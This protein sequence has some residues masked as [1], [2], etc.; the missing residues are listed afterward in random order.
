MKPL[1]KLVVVIVFVLSLMLNAAHAASRYTSLALISGVN[2]DVD[3]QVRTTD[4]ESVD[5][6]KRDNIRIRVR[7][8]SDLVSD[9]LES[10]AVITINMYDVINGTREFVRSQS[11]TVRT[12][13]SGRRVISFDV[14]E[15]TSESKEVEFD[16][17]DTN[18]NLV[19]TYSATLNATNIS[20]QASSNEGLSFTGTTCDPTV[21]FDECMPLLMERLQ[22]VSR[23]ARQQS[24]MVD[25]TDNV[26]RVLSPSRR[27]FSRIRGSRRKVNVSSSSDSSTGT[28]VASDFGEVLDASTLRLGESALDFVGLTNSNGALSVTSNGIVLSEGLLPTPTNGAIEFDGTDYF[29]TSGGVRT[30]IGAGTVGP[31][32]PQGA[33]GAQGPAGADGSDGAQGPAGTLTSNSGVIVANGG[34]H[35]SNGS[36]TGAPTVDIYNGNLLGTTTINGTLNI[37]NGATAGYVLTSDANGNATWQAP[38]GGSTTT[39]S[40]NGASLNGSTLTDTDLDGIVAFTPTAGA[41]PVDADT[42]IAVTNSIMRIEGNGGPVTM[43]ADPQIAAGEKDGQFLIVKGMSDTNTVTFV[44]GQGIELAFNGIQFTLGAGDTLTLIYDAIDTKWIEVSR[45]DNN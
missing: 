24:F 35:I 16:L 4:L 34:L 3:F 31:A 7:G 20:A 38:T 43:T 45:S 42:S 13:S 33:Q 18:N 8:I 12:G 1:N 11:L 22:F 26:W 14:G 28:T 44:D 15:F 40:A 21:S 29:I 10:F 30:A 5:F 37:V 25:R 23:P 41:V 9:S 19:N 32:G 36:I 39:I 6:L 17:L 27:N 2:P